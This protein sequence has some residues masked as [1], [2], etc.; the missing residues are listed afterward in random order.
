MLLKSKQSK[1]MTSVKCLLICVEDMI[2]TEQT[3]EQVSKVEQRVAGGE[4]I[5]GGGGGGAVSAQE[6]FEAEAGQETSSALCTCSVL[7]VDR[8]HEE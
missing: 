5:R 3:S 8:H 4:C 2:A 7:K 1:Q 6:I